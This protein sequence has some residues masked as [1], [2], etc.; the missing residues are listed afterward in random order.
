MFEI[1]KGIRKRPV[2]ILIYGV[3]G[4][5]KTELASHFGN[6]LFFDLE[7]GVDF[8]NVDSVKLKN[9]DELKKAIAWGCKQEHDTLVF[10]SWSAVERM[11]LAHTL[12]TNGLKSLSQLDYG[13]GYALLRDNLR[14]V[15]AGIQ[16]AQNNGKNVIVVAHA[17]VK[18]VEDPML[19]S[20]DRVQFDCEK[21]M[22]NPLISICDGCFYF[23][24]MIRALENKDKETKVVSSGAK[25]LLLTD[26]GS[27]MSKSR[28]NHMDQSYEFDFE[29]SDELRAKMYKEFW[30]KLNNN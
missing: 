25:E 4:V 1:H 16:Y 30:K 9:F 17:L 13:K 15:L 19:P 8:F 28:F 24:P 21:E 29:Q 2:I 14:S 10:D 26:K 6:T 23:R 27:A 3:P 11:T 18:R 20:Y 5:G 22:V 12:E 7:N